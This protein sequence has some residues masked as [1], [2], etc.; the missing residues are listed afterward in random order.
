[1]R[2]LNYV[3]TKLNIH[4]LFV[5]ASFKSKYNFKYHL[6]NQIYMASTSNYQFF[7]LLQWKDY[8]FIYLVYIV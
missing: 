7:R 5:F 4:M 3:L 6:N 1:M 8:F 2:I